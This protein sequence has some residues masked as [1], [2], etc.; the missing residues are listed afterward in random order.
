VQFIPEKAK[1]PRILRIATDVFIEN[2]WRFVVFGSNFKLHPKACEL[3]TST[4]CAE[5]VINYLVQAL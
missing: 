2:P 3:L 4:R 1:M 5:F